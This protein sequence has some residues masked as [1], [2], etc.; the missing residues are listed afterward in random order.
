MLHVSAQKKPGAGRN[1]QI[2]SL[3]SHEPCVFQSH[4]SQDYLLK[5]ALS[6]IIGATSSE[7]WRTETHASE[8]TA[9][10]RS[11]TQDWL[12]DS[13]KNIRLIGCC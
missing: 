11:H 12:A 5:S 6:S 2:G 4:G 7:E 10:A 1:M 8:N 13:A 9:K 3:N